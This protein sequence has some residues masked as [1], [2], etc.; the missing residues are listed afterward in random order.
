MTRPLLAALALTMLVSGCATIRDSRFNPLGWFGGSRS[1]P[2]SLGPTAIST[3]T[4]PLVA[5][6]TALALEPTS[7]GAI[8][9]A[10]GLSP[11][12]GWWDGELVPQTSLR[13]IDGVVVYRF[14]IAPPT[15]P[16]RVSTPQSRAVSV[17]ATLSRAELA[18]IREIVVVGA[19]NQRSLRR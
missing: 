17:A 10:E 8:V 7:T 13:P 16:T 12:Q 4:R 14:H 1:A 15:E 3:E 6:V 19:E 9:R 5:Q 18:E 11:T 2:V